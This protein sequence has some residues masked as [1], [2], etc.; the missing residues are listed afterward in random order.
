MG[1]SM[2]PLQLAC[3]VAT[4]TIDVLPPSAAHTDYSSDQ[5]H[6]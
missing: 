6:G 2:P 1:K 4:L 5:D 3:M